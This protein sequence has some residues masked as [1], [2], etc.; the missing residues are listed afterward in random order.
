MQQTLD[1]CS[2][3]K[4]SLLS[5][6]TAEGRIDRWLAT[7]LKE[8]FSRSYVKILILNGFIS[9]NGMVSKNPNRKVVPGD[10]F[11]ITVPAAQ[12][13]N[14]AQENIP[15]DILYEDDDIIVINKPA[16]LVVHP[17][18]GNWT[19]TLVNA[20]LYHCHNNLSSING[21]KRPGIVHRLDKDTTGVMVVAKNDLAHQKL[22]EQFVDH[23]KS[24]RLKRAYYAMVWGIPLPD[25]GIINAPLGRCKSNRLRRAVKGID[26]K[27]A[28]SAITHYQTIEIYNKNSNFAVSLLKCH[29][30]TGRT[31]QI[32]VHMAHKGNPLIGD[33]LYGK[34]FKTKANIVN[35][36]AKSA[37]LSLAR[38]A[39]HA[40]S[41]SFSHPRN[42]QDM[43]FQV[44]IPEDMLTVIRKLNEK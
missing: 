16:G 36:N 31:H 24:T 8:Q 17:A 30:E 2:S 20:L 25:S 11:L 6:S 35:N 1:N 15:L 3:I 39:L 43:D 28:D 40:H 37:I 12:K 22:S 44:P 18:P 33:P 5:D 10:S 14:I 32:R 41:L 42:N 7:S 34:G 9:I 21:V 19:G 4:I 13:L 27:T 29:L 23:G 38:Q 26:D